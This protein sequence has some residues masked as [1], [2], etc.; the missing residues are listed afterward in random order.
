MPITAAL[1]GAAQVVEKV[2]MLMLAPYKN[3]II[4]SLYLSY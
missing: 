1:Y 4:D 3:F 2:R